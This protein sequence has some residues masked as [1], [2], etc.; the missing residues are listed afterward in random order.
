MA[1]RSK[2]LLTSSPY[3]L[4][5][6][7][8]DLENVAQF[9]FSE[10]YEFGGNIQTRVIGAATQ[11]ALKESLW[12]EPHRGPLTELLDG[13][14]GAL[15][16]ELV[17]AG[18][19]FTEYEKSLIQIGGGVDGAKID[20]PGILFP[21]TPNQG[22]TTR[23]YMLEMKC[24]FPVVDWNGELISNHS[25]DYY[26]STG[27]R[28]DFKKAVDK[29]TNGNWS[30]YYASFAMLTVVFSLKKGG[31]MS[32]RRGGLRPLYA[33]TGV[34]YVITMAAR[35]RSF[36]AVFRNHIE[37]YVAVKIVGDGIYDGQR[38]LKVLWD[39]NET[40]LVYRDDQ[41]WTEAYIDWLKQR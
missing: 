37:K 17:E 40:S 13:V 35:G 32:T 6:S 39:N 24:H 31:G 7:A 33:C 3:S 12:G 28:T 36:A 10:D 41:D 29:A 20:F 34:E 26:V 4:A 9:F 22:E 30:P 14:A 38:V 11:Q 27:C 18:I 16:G 2:E 25:R 21:A 1:W 23:I 5:L 19:V 15:K 8:G